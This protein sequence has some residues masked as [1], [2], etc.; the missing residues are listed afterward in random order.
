[1]SVCYLIFKVKVIFLEKLKTIPS[2]VFEFC[3]DKAV[4][5]PVDVL[6][7]I[8]SP[9][10]IEAVSEQICFLSGMRNASYD[11]LDDDGLVAPGTRVS[12]DDVIVGKTVTLP[13]NDDEV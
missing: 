3:F 10:L 4:R 6:E 7:L 2:K 12:G 11:K 9:T 8:G 13:E 5:S 1:M